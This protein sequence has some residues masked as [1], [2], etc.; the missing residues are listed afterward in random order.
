MTPFFL[1][2]FSNVLWE[3]GPTIDFSIGHIGI[4]L[5]RGFPPSFFKIKLPKSYTLP[6]MMLWNM[7]I[8]WNMAMFGINSLDFWGVSSPNRSSE[9]LSPKDSQQIPLGSRPN[10]KNYIDQF[11]ADP[12]DQNPTQKFS[13]SFPNVWKIRCRLFWVPNKSWTWSTPFPCRKKD[14]FGPWK[15]NSRPLKKGNFTIRWLFLFRFGH[16]F[17]IPKLGFL[18]CFNRWL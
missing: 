9:I 8:L 6:K 2:C 4:P 17:I 7:Y 12:S 11:P 15:S 1:I 18:L 16:L 3:N 13:V 10:K 14:I 5:T